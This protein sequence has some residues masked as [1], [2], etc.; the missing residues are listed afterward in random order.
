MSALQSWLQ[1]QGFIEDPFGHYTADNTP[2]EMLQATYIYDSTLEDLMLSN[3]SVAILAPYGG[4]KTMA[5]RYW[6]TQWQKKH[7]DALIVTY[8]DFAVP[9]QHLPQAA[10]KNHIPSLLGCLAESAW[11]IFGPTQER[12]LTLTDNDQTWWWA[13]LD[14]YYPEQPFFPFY[15]TESPDLRNSY[16]RLFAANKIK[17]FG[18]QQTLDSRLHQAVPYLNRAGFS[19]L[20][21]L[22]DEVDAQE[23]NAP[24]MIEKIASP[25][26]NALRLFSNEKIV[27]KYFLPDSIAGMVEN[28]AAVLKLRVTTQ[29]ISWNADQLKALLQSRLAWAS[30][31][32]VDSLK[33]LKLSEEMPQL[34]DDF[35]ALV[36]KNQSRHGAP[37]T[38]LMYGR[39]LFTTLATRT[40]NKSNTK[41]T[42]QEFL[43]LIDDTNPDSELKT[44]A[45][46]E[47]IEPMTP[48]ELRQILVDHFNLDELRQL[49]FDLYI[50]YEELPGGDTLSP[51]AQSLVEY[52]QRHGKM[53]EL[54]EQISQARPILFVMNEDM[55]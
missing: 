50:N 4:G 49:C 46:R 15:L 30:G 17:L 54:K 29:R 31:D 1:S 11:K 35:I 41:A 55:N 34:D 9:A 52:C 39:I 20:L 23:Q 16:E 44:V 33:K 13:L 6:Q 7:S 12:L 51:K 26:L 18:E 27:W 10:L 25:L 40:D 42:W 24:L 21:I 28:S 43:D 3:Q 5:R 19:R 45:T 48:R 22:V 38:L 36:E 2:A 14:S 32:A 37:R 47:Q 8:N 53:A